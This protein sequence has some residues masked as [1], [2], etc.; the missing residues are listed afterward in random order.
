MLKLCHK[1][2]IFRSFIH[3]QLNKRANFITE[4][5]DKAQILNII[6][7]KTSIRFIQIFSTY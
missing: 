3:K 7:M 6:Y 4:V 5:D 2:K 1:Y